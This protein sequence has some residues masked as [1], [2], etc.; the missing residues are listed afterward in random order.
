MNGKRIQLVAVRQSD[1]DAYLFKA[2][3]WSC[4]P[5][6]EVT[7]ATR[8]GEARGTVLMVCDTD[9]REEADKI[10]AAFGAKR[11]LSTVLSVLKRKDLVFDEKDWNDDEEAIPV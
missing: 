4:T 1:N 11:P 6:D 2:P 10:A 8:H 7:V 9:D 5:G 3:R